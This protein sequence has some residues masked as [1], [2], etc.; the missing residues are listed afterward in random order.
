MKSCEAN[1]YIHAR[2]LQVVNR[3]MHCPRLQRLFADP[4]MNARVRGLR[5]GL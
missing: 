2:Y 3:D 5:Q 1:H 4:S